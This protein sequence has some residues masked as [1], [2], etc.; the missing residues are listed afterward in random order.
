MHGRTYSIVPVSE[1]NCPLPGLGTLLIHNRTALYMQSEKY[2][3][4]PLPYISFSPV[5]N[6]SLDF[7]DHTAKK[8]SV[9]KEE[10]M[11][12]INTFCLKLNNLDSFSEVE[13]PLAGKFYIDAEGSLVFKPVHFPEV[14]LAPVPAERISHPEATHS[15][16][17]GDTESNSALMTEYY[18]ESEPASTSRWW[19]P[20]LVLALLSILVI[21]AYFISNDNTNTVGNATKLKAGKEEKTYKIPD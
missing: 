9:S 2:L 4:P 10:A 18:S 13:I 5:E 19:I 16:L 7:V 8:L 11:N 14:F 6:P 3:T 17:V 12:I 21:A 20:A 1:K 15:I